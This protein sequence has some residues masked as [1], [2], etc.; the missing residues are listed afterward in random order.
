MTEVPTEITLKASALTPEMHE[1]LTTGARFNFK[2]GPPSRLFTA[3]AEQ[4][5]EP[6][7]IRIFDIQ[8]ARPLVL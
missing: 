1:A 3:R 7:L 4:A 6:G 2:L 8:D 5:A